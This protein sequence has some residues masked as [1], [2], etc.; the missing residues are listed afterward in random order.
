LRCTVGVGDYVDDNGAIITKHDFENGK[1]FEQKL[2]KK[3]K[4]LLKNNSNVCE[5]K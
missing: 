5:S 3:I 2:R 1:L 4:N